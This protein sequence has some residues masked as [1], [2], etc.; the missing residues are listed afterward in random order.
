MHFMTEPQTKQDAIEARQLQKKLANVREK[1]A[2]ELV[3]GLF[4]VASGTLGI[5]W[6]RKNIRSGWE[7][8]FIGA[9]GAGIGSIISGLWNGR[10]ATSLSSAIS[11]VTESL[12]VTAAPKTASSITDM[13]DKPRLLQTLAGQQEAADSLHVESRRLQ[14]SSKS[15][16]AAGTIGL[17]TSVGL[18]LSWGRKSLVGGWTSLVIAVG[19]L[20]ATIIAAFK[21]EKAGGIDH[22]LNRIPTISITPSS[23]ERPRALAQDGQTNDKIWVESAAS[24]PKTIQRM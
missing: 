1:S 22:A 13:E 7:N 14:E 23:A 21:E 6:A 12:P 8:F 24:K 19:S 11:K 4:V 15:W 18:G 5:I 3:T 20:L 9:S 10:K 2:L 17:M 16:N